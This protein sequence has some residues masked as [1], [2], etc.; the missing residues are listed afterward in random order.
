MQR[1]DH[2]DAGQANAQALLDLENGAT[3][4][5]L[6]FAGGPG[7]RG[8]GLPDASKETLKRVFDGIFLDAGIAIAL[9]PV[10][11]GEN[12]GMNFAGLVESR[13]IDPSKVDVRFNYQPLTTMAVRGATPAP[14]VRDGARTWRRSSANLADRGFKGPFVLAD[15]RP[16]HDA[17]GSE[18]QELGFA[19]A[20]A[21]AY[22]RAL[23]G[24]RY[25]ARRRQ[26]SNLVS[27]QRR[28]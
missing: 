6:E 25:R 7:A 2:P 23:E 17:G 11:G 27:A 13:G 1:I 15:G 22:L 3:G 18:A 14:W 12:A 10:L 9:H 19:L 16:V 26:G 5:Q 24:R 28:R 8:Y 20:V 4:L 21:V